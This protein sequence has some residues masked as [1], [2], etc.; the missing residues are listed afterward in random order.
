[1]KVI[2]KTP[3]Q[4]EKG[5]FTMVE[6]IKGMLEFGLSWPSEIEAQK[7]VVTQL[8]RVLEKGYTLLRNLELE[9]SK[10][11]VPLIL[12]GPAGVFVIHVMPEKGFF[13]ADGDQWNIV[14][15]ERRTPAASNPMSRIARLARALQVYLNR[16]GVV[17]PGMIEPVLIAA[18]AAVQIEVNRPLVRVVLSDGIKQFGASLLQT[19]PLL[20]S[21]AVYDVVDHLV[22]P[23]SKSTAAAPQAGAPGASAAPAASAVQE[24]ASAPAPATLGRSFRPPR[25]P[26]PSTHRTWISSSRRRAPPAR[27]GT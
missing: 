23:R 4:D 7:P 22:N 10:I 3:H 9:H 6:R 12:V 5:D 21:E 14:Q 16:Q 25:R 11:I 2:D 13:E 20:N 24:P 1:M 15:G 27:P 17:L 19:R 18:S 8:D 26:S